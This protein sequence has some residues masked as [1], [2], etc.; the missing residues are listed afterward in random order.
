MF[1]STFCLF[2]ISF[3]YFATSIFYFR[4]YVTSIFGV[5]NSVTSIFCLS[6]FFLFVFFS[7]YI[8]LSIFYPF[9]HLYSTFFDVLLSVFCRVRYLYLDIL[10]YLFLSFRC[11]AF[12]VD[13]SLIRFFCDSISCIFDMRFDVLQFDILH[14]RYIVPLIFCDFDIFAPSIFCLSI[15]CV[16]CFSIRYFAF[17]CFVIEAPGMAARC[18]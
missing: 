11:S 15:S 13:I 6:I 8:L 7:F 4:C 14:F 18:R 5:R 2:L 12:S 3:R 17:R 9:D 10:F 16:R 1:C